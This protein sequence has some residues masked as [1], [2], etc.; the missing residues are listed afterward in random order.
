VFDLEEQEGL[1]M[2]F[3][4]EIVQEYSRE[5]AMRRERFI[6]PEAL[7]PEMA[8]ERM[9]STARPPVEMEEEKP[10]LL[11]LAKRRCNHPDHDKPDWIKEN[12][13]VEE[14]FP[15]GLFMANVKEERAAYNLPVPGYYRNRRFNGF[16]PFHRHTVYGTYMTTVGKWIEVYM[17][18]FKVSAARQGLD[19]GV[20]KAGGLDPSAYDHPVTWHPPESVFE[21]WKSIGWRAPERIEEVWAREAEGEEISPEETRQIEE[22]IKKYE[23]VT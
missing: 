18:M 15:G 23:G 12:P 7:S 5:V 19:P 20:V 21:Y 22:D 14:E 10:Q 8:I 1:A 16:C 9:V 3:A 2:D 17:W 6:K 4:M 13:G 11:G